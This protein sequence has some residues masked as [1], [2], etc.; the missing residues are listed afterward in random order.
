MGRANRSECEQSQDDDRDDFAAVV[1]F[2]T[3]E[4]RRKPM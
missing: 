3:A 1:T 2:M 4:A